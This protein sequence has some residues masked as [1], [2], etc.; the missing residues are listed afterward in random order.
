MMEAR[1]VSSLPTAAPHHDVVRCLLAI[2]L[3]KTS[4][5]VAVHTPLSD[6]I[7]RYTLEG[8]D[9]KGLLELIERIRKRVTR[10][11]GPSVEMISCYE[12]SYDGFWLHRLLEGHG[13]RNHVIDPASLQVDR[14]VRRAKTDR[15]DAARLLR[16]LMA[17]VRG[18]PKVWSVVRVPSVAE[19]DDRRLHRERDRLIN[20]RGQHVN[21]IKGL[22][23][24]HG[25]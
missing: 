20:E 18:E 6:K 15:I 16:S 12:A 8:C 24:V 13:V 17:H 1:T 21:R 7:S 14:R 22:C 23:A 10:E 9:W 11:F 3:S 2:E 4:W 19:E 25:I 5:V